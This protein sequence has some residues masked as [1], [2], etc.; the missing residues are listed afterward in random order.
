[1]NG[2]PRLDRPTYLALTLL[3]AIAALVVG[4]SAGLAN[5]TDQFLLPID[6]EFAD[7][8]PYISSVHYQV[9]EDFVTRTNRQI[10]DAKREPD[11]LKREAILQQAQS[12]LTAAN[13]VRAAFGP[14][15]FETLELE[16]VLRT[17]GAKALFPKGIAAF[18]TSNWIYSSVHLPF[19]PRKIPLALPSS[20]IRVFDHYIGTD[21]FGHFHDLGHIYH[22]DFVNLCNLGVDR[23]EALRRVVAD[24]SRG[25]ISEAGSI[26]FFATGVFSNGDLAANYLGFKFYLNLTEPVMLK[27]ELQPPMLVRQGEYWSLNTHVRPDSNFFSA[28]VSDHLNE[29]LNPCVY[30]WGAAGP[31]EKKLREHANQILTF[32][33]DEQGNKRPREWFEAMER[34]LATYYGEDYGHSKLENATVTIA[35]CCFGP[36]KPPEESRSP[37][38]RSPW[39]LSTD[40]PSLPKGAS[41]PGCQIISSGLAT[42][43]SR[44]EHHAESSTPPPGKE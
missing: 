26:G 41:R 3:V 13:H 9:L 30:E 10:R 15:F 23:G 19:D 42:T 7:V 43:L 36:A 2:K 6:Q 39:P 35:T 25:P 44:L 27:G 16:N 12:P 22:K 21:K 24:Y 4:P 14:G 17:Q 28:F 20:T 18:K 31:I 38:S 33:A 40:S 8:G 37:T 5:E 34:S 29:A 32:Y 11:R 1:M